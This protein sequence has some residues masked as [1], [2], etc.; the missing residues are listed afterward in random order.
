MTNG[1]THDVNLIPPAETKN[2]PGLHPGIDQILDIKAKEGSNNLVMEFLTQRGFIH[3]DIL[4]GTQIDRDR[5]LAYLL[6][7]DANNVEGFSTLLAEF[8]A[9]PQYC[10]PS[11]RRP[12][13]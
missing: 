11:E 12:E 2:E 9:G 13:V 3:T 4:D 1:P 7:R 10:P 6:D 8:K 5:L